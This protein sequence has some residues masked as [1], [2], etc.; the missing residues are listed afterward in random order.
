[1]VNNNS[2]QVLDLGR[3]HALSPNSVH[4]PS[5]RNGDDNNKQ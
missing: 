3:N 4:L 2:I 5:Q 1:M